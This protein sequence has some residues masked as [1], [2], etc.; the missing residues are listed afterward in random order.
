MGDGRWMPRDNVILTVGALPAA[1]ERRQ[2]AAR[3]VVWLA[4]FA[5][6]VRY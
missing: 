1:C 4:R 6:D 5:A 2:C 3:I